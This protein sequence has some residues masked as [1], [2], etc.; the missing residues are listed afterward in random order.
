MQEQTC[1][2]CGVRQSQVQGVFQLDHFVPRCVGGSNKPENLIVACRF[3]N[4]AKAGNQFRTIQDAREWLHWTLW[5]K[6]RQRY[7][8]YRK[9]CF[10]GKPPEGMPVESPEM[11]RIALRKFRLK[12]ELAFAATASR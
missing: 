4:Q 5:G 12:Q 7:V 10:G 11:A 9:V 8:P 6:N 3:C 2:Y 1:G